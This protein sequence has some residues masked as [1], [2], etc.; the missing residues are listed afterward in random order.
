MRTTS[1]WQQAQRYFSYLRAND[2]EHSPATLE[3]WLRS[4]CELHP[5]IA[6]LVRQTVYD[7]LGV[8]PPMPQVDPET[9]KSWAQKYFAYLR[10]EDM[11]HFDDRL[12]LWLIF[13]ECPHELQNPV[14]EEVERQIEEMCRLIDEVDN[15][16]AGTS[17]NPGDGGEAA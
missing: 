12:L 5:Q 3:A 10:S 7:I 15:E 13:Q 9:V 1:A 16:D 6:W 4:D 14:E 8:D 2:L 17:G 11:A